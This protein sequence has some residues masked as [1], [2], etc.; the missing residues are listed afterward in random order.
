MQSTY[1]HTQSRRRTV[2]LTLKSKEEEDTGKPY[3]RR[4]QITPS[5]ACIVSSQ[6][7]LLDVKRFCT[8]TGDNFSALPIDTTFNIGDFYVKPTI[9]RHLLLED[10]RTGNPPL[11]MGPTI[12]HMRKDTETFSYF[13]L[14]LTGQEY[15]HTSSIGNVASL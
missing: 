4:L 14:A 2:H 6:R 10:K 9:F 8:N 7:Q 1:N 3:I 15:E 13:G 12:I 11:L 5:P